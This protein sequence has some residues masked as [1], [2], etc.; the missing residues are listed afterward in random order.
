MLK[1]EL[2]ELL[3]LTNAF[4]QEHGLNVLTW[5]DDLAEAAEGHAED[6]AAK[7]YVSHAQPD[8]DALPDR[9]DQAGYDWW[10]AGENIAMGPRSAEE[11]FEAWK[12]SP[13]HRANMLNPSFE[14]MGGGHAEEGVQPDL[15]VQVFGS[16]WI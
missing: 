16:E 5:D 15:W 7:D 2:H 4:R 10:T 8:G 1:Q 6:M 11:A 14:E 13:G 12:D 9:L 3:D